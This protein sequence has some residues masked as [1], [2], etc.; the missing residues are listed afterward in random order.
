M[1]RSYTEKFCFLGSYL[2][3]TFVSLCPFLKHFIGSVPKR[4]TEFTFSKP[5]VSQL[6]YHWSSYFMLY[7]HCIS[8]FSFIHFFMFPFYSPTN[9]LVF[10]KKTFSKTC[11][12]HIH[13]LYYS[14]LSSLE[15]IS[16][17]LTCLQRKMLI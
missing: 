16:G 11:L 9:K 3:E 12:D 2:R 10:S 7:E 8:Y 13:I 6:S 15:V 5:L 1:H 4:I 17:H 14:G